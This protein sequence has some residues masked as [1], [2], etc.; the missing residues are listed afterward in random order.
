[1]MVFDSANSHTCDL[2]FVNRWSNRL[3]VRFDSILN[4]LPGCIRWLTEEE[5]DFIRIKEM[6]INLM[7]TTLKTVEITGVRSASPLNTQNKHN[8]ELH[9]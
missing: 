5:D 2:Y 1:M 7:R 3:D 8:T 4:P 9:E 6:N